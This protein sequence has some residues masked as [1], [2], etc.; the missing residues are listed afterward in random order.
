MTKEQQRIA[1]ATAC[2]W[3]K[4][5]QPDNEQDE[6][7]GHWEWHRGN[8]NLRRLPDYLQDLN[9]MA[10][11]ETWLIDQKNPKQIITYCHQLHG[12]FCGGLFSTA[13]QR[14]EAFLRT[15]GL[16]QEGQGK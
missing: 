10:E 7:T 2:G 9:A 8:E 13:A 1:I 6:A 5:W 11:V 15:L 14:A 12:N 16:W 3:T 4:F